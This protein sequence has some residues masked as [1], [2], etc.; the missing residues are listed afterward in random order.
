MKKLRIAYLSADDPKNK[1]IWSGTLYSMYRMLSE[2]AEVEMLGPWMPKMHVLFYRILNQI[3]LRIRGLRISYRHSIDLAKDYGA[4]FSKVLAKGNYDLIF[5]PAASSQI[6]FL[7]TDVPIIYLAD[8]TFAGCLN[9]HAALSNLTNNSVTEGNKVE[10]LAVKKS[11]RVIVTSEWAAQSVIKDYGAESEKVKVIPFGANLELV[12]EN[13]EFA[14]V[15][16]P[17]WKVLFPAVYWGNKGGNIALNALAILSEEGWP[18]SMTVLGCEPPEGVGHKNMQVVPFID[19]NDPNAN[20]LFDRI[21]SS[22]HFLILPTRFDCTPVVIN[23]ASAYGIPSLVAD[24]G[25]VRGH[26]ENGVN[27]F[28]IN[29]NDGGEGYANILREHFKDPAKYFELQKKSRR[30]YMEKLN[31]QHWLSE[32]LKTALEIVK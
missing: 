3:S 2:K 7:E 14:G 27:G 6:A 4:H 8:G 18:V 20:D 12:P 32:F 1:R 19:K 17:V 15:V 22:H 9:Y 16:P 29:Y 13:I 10:D 21:Y 26:L 5:A 23:E 30:L 31:W 25:G 28:L 24:T 11:S